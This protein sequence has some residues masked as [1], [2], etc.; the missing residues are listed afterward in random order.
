M[1]KIAAVAVR[2]DGV[3]LMRILPRR[4][5]DPR[6]NVAYHCYL[7]CE[8][9]RHHEAEK[10]RSDRE[11]RSPLRGSSSPRTGST[12]AGRERRRPRRPAHTPSS[13]EQTGKE[14]FASRDIPGENKIG[15]TAEKPRSRQKTPLT[16]ARLIV[17]GSPAYQP[18]RPPP[19]QPSS[20]TSATVGPTMPAVMSHNC[21]Y[22]HASRPLMLAA[23]VPISART[24]ATSLRPSAISDPRAAPASQS[25]L[26]ARWVSKG[27]NSWTPLY[28]GKRRYVNGGD[29]GAVRYESAVGWFPSPSAPHHGAPLPRVWNSPSVR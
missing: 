11:N 9:A 23:T 19:G 7:P 27:A 1:L 8:D 16:I 18:F 21:R 25:A 6:H 4:Q 24:L 28:G 29:G 2:P 5:Q 17:T 3:R 15:S 10:H 26:M 13:A 12:P 20:L 22:S 14:A